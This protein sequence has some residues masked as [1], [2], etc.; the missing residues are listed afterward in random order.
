MCS[1]VHRCIHVE[2]K[3]KLD[4][5]DRFIALIICL[6]CFGHFYTHH[7]ELEVILCYYRLWCTVLGCWL[8]GVRCRAVGYA[9]RKRDVTRRLVQHPSS[10]THSLLL[11][12]SP[13]T[14]RNQVLYTIG[15]NNTRAPD[16]GH[17]SARNMLSIL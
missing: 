12:I 9:S 6:T 2:K 3:N 13:P 4:A 11:C 10:W 16:D 15:S 14:N 17:R 8:P 1:S 7:Q 5:T